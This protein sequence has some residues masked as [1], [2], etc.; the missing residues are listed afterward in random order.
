VP[1]KIRESESFS[2]RY[3]LLQEPAFFCRAKRVLRALN[4]ENRHKGWG[5]GYE[6]NFTE[7]VA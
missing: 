7:R 5:I 6:I 3:N 2:F 1:Q 4:W